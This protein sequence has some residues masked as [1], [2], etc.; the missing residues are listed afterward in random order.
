MPQRGFSSLPDLDGQLDGN[1][2]YV[3]R[4]VFGGCV[5]DDGIALSGGQGGG[6][7]DFKFHPV[8]IQGDFTQG[9]VHHSLGGQSSQGVRVFVGEDFFLSYTIIV[10]L[11]D[12]L[13]PSAVFTVIFDDPPIPLSI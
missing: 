7:C 12:L 10:I 8:P 13:V 11:A 1:G 6:V 4:I 5:Q 2:F 3:F 9:G